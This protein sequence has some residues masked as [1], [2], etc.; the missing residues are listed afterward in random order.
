MSATGNHDHSDDTEAELPGQLEVELERTGTVW[1]ASAHIFFFERQK[2]KKKKRC[3]RCQRA[4]HHGGDR[5]R[6]AVAPVGRRAAGLGGRPRRDGA[7]RRRHLLH[8]HPPRRVL[9]LRRSGDPL[10]AGKRNRTYMDAVR[11]T[12]GG[13]KQRLCAAVQLSNLFGIG[14]GITI[15]AS[16][17]MRAIRKAGCFHARGH[18][19]PCRA[20]TTPYIAIYGA[21]QIVFSQIPDLGKVWWL[22]T[23]AAV[24]SLSYSAIGISLGIAQ[25]VANGGLKGRLTGVIGAAAG[26]SKMQKVWRSLQAFGNIAFAYGFSMILLEIQDTIKAPPPS[27]AKVMKKATA[28]SVVVTTVVYLLCGCVGYAAFGGEAPDNLLTGFGFYE[29]F[30]L[31]D[32]ANA[33]VVVHLTGTYQVMSQPVFA[34]VERR[35]AG[36]WPGSALVR[37][38]DVRVGPRANNGVRREPDAAGVAHGVLCV[39]TAVAMALPFFGAVVGLIGAASFWPLTVYI[40]VEMY[41]ARRGVARGSARWVLLQALSAGCLVVSVAAAAGSVAGVVGAFKAHSPF[42]WEC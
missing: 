33:G 30:W 17:S 39:T 19:D 32:A 15:A 9:P 6:R 23:V 29:P 13:S 24:M 8:L 35:A 42:C 3:A 40:P 38:R 11:A 1:T 12:L 36:A 28:V 16:V 10:A 2:K 25:I 21:V 22:S 4:H 27:E 5:L 20:S 14:V 31:L 34:Y 37:A 18:E 7:L 26:V 41:V